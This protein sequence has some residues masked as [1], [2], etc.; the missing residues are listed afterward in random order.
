MKF[1]EPAPDD[2]IL[3]TGCRRYQPYADTG[4][5]AKTGRGTYAEIL[6]KCEWFVPMKDAENQK[7]G[8]QRWPTLE[9]DILKSREE[10]SKFQVERKRA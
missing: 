9:A 1:Y 7:T 10:K 2:R 4:K 5:C 6:R 3:C 8:M